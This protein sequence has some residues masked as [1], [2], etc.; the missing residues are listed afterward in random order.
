VK[1]A[2]E[3][4]SHRVDSATMGQFPGQMTAAMEEAENM[5]R[6]QVRLF[7]IEPGVCQV[8]EAWSFR[9]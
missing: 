4:Q 6:T 9:W 2:K 7:R 3:G 1:T 8:A 5:V